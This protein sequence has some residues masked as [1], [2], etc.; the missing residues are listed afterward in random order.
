MNFKTIVLFLFFSPLILA[1]QEA[2]FKLEAS[3]LTVVL[4]IKDGNYTISECGLD[5]KVKQS[6]G[7]VTQVND[8]LLFKDNKSETV[9]SFVNEKNFIERPSKV[10]IKLSFISMPSGLNKI[11]DLS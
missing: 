8:S 1:A 9:R 2:Q 6:K 3:S 10:I 11:S 7:A 4:V 5:G